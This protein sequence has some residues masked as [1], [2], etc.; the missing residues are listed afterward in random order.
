MVEDSPY[1]AV[2]NGNR[3]AKMAIVCEAAEIRH[4]KMGLR[5]FLSFKEKNAVIA[6]L[7]RVFLTKKI[8]KYQCQMD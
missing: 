5:D 4:S 3:K 1:I 7:Q 2:L 6:S 8:G